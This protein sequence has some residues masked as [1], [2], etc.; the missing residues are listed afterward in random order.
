MRGL[1]S[2]LSDM[3]CSV[4]WSAISFDI[5]IFV[6]TWFN[7]GFSDAEL[8]LDSYRIYRCARNR[9]T[10]NCLRQGGVLI[11]VCECLSS[12][13]LFSINNIIAINNIRL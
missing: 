12:R 6:E 1:R 13:Q 5:I 10:S 7:D 8:G 3:H 2:Q 9:N 11:A 4:A